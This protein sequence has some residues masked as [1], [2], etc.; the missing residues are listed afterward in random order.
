MNVLFFNTSIV[1]LFCLQPSELN[2]ISIFI[3]FHGFLIGKIGGSS[4]FQA[5]SVNAACI[6]YDQKI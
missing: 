5:Y 6:F 2:G 4:Y 1:L 3:I